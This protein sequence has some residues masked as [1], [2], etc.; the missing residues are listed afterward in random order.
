VFVP[1]S[2]LTS[3]TVLA[4]IGAARRRRKLTDARQATMFE[5]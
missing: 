4:V 1:R 2:A 5:E 3:V